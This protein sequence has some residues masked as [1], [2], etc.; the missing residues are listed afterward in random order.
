MHRLFLAAFITA[1]ALHADTFTFTSCTQ[2]TTTFSPCPPGSGTTANAS[3]NSFFGGGNPI[4]GGQPMW[5]GTAVSV[6]SSD[7]FAVSATAQASAFNTFDSA[8]AA[9]QGFIQFEVF[10]D[11]NHG[12][13]STV[14]LTDGVHTYSYGAF[15]CAGSTPLTRGNPDFDC[16]WDSTQ[17]FDLGSEF[18]VTVSSND[19]ASL[20][21]GSSQGG[22][23]SGSDASVSFRLL[24]ADGTTAVPLSIIPEPSTWTLLLLGLSACGR[25]AWSRRIKH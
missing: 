21:A 15:E 9:R 6:V 7:M 12:G 18:H 5:A 16:V 24:D 4:P 14:V 2:G 17:P 8:G 20:P 3:D 22:A 13:N 19:A 1:F 11:R 10:T 23:G 25:V